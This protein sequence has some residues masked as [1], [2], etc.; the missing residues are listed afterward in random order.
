MPWFGLAAKAA[1]GE[2]CLMCVFVCLFEK[3]VY[4][5][6]NYNGFKGRFKGFS[7]GPGGNQ[8]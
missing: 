7:G 5:V 3:T 4:I 2:H 8:V 6:I 1:A